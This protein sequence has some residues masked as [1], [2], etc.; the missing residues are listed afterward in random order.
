MLDKSFYG[1]GGIKMGL[2]PA[3]L[4]M[5]NSVIDG[6]LDKPERLFLVTIGDDSLQFHQVA[7]IKRNGGFLISSIL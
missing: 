1:V 3:P 2:E 4:S 5:H 6:L 7:L